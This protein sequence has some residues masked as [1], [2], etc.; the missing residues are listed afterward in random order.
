MD[1]LFISSFPISSSLSAVISNRKVLTVSELNQALS[2]LV[3]TA[4]PLLWV[5]GEISSFT[6]AASGHWYFTLKDDDSQIRAVMFRGRARLA[7]FIPKRGDHIEVRATLSMYMARGEFQLKVESIRHAG[8]GNQ[9]EAF[10]RM[11]AYLEAEGLFDPGRKCHIPAFVKT[12]GVV[13]SPQAAALH[14]VMTTLARR[15]PHVQIILYPT[16]VQGV[17]AAGKIAEAIATA[18]ERAECDAL[19]VCRGGGSPEDLWSF[20]EEP[21]ARGIA[22]CQI[23]VISGVGHETDFTIADFVADVRAPTPTGAAELVSRSHDDWM[24]ILASIAGQMTRWMNRWLQQAMQHADMLHRRLVSPVA[25]IQQERLQLK[26]SAARLSSLQPDTRVMG[27]QLKSRKECL[28]SAMH[29]M[30]SGQRQ[31][32]TSLLAKLKLLSPHQILNRGYAIMQNDRGQI[33]HSPAE[34]PIK[35]PISVRLAGGTAEIVVDSV[36]PTSS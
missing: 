12:V 10:L 16:Q 26:A 1:N 5:S 7:E 33:I 2:Q 31:K 28:T 13:T 25:Y 23:P 32:V 17:D 34:I 8:A 11:K 35:K 3:E 24:D 21:V 14:D 6:R 4:V 18:S 29:N 19:I 20:N 9:Y 15:A 27:Y 36:Q 30:L 22:A